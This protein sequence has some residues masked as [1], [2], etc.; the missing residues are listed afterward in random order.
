MAFRVHRVER[1]PR[2]DAHRTVELARA[3]EIIHTICRET[4]PGADLAERSQSR[5]EVNIERWTNSA[6]RGRVPERE[7]GVYAGLQ[8]DSVES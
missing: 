4:G 8:I 7:A 6:R 1:D 2:L 3:S 5:R